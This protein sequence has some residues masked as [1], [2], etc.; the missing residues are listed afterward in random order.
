MSV[1]ATVLRAQGHGVALWIHGG[2]GAEVCTE[3]LL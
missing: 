1:P 2:C 3:N